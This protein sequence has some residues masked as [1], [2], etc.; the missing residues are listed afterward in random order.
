MSRSSLD[1]RCPK[2][3][4]VLRA[5]V[6]RARV[7]LTVAYI[8]PLYALAEI[9]AVMGGGWWQVDI[10][11]RRM[12]HKLTLAELACDEAGDYQFTRLAARLIGSITIAVDHVTDRL[13]A[14]I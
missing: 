9:T 3:A 11:L 5:R 8:A 10:H 14:R 7:L 6:R 1:R 13:A 12:D 4:A 2:A